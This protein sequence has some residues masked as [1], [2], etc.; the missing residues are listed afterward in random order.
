[1]DFS[2]KEVLMNNY[3]L[4]ADD[5]YDAR[6]IL[7]SIV[8]SLGMRPVAVSN[9]ALVLDVVHREKPD[10]ILL[11]LLMPDMDGFSVLKHLQKNPAT[12]NIP[13]IVLSAISDSRFLAMLG[14]SRIVPKAQFSVQ[15]LQEMIRELVPQQETVK[16]EVSQIAHSSDTVVV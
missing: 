14:V 12:K 3:I 1:V 5:D 4:I 16:H 11:D 2:V 7:K 15:D 6:E 8:S 9:G 10:L 13:V